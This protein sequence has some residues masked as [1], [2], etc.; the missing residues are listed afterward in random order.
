M[1][2]KIKDGVRIG[3]VDVFN[4]DGEL[5]VNSPTTTK[6][7][8]SRTISLSG[9]VTGSV[10]FDGSS[11]VS[12]T[13]TIGAN[14]VALGTDTTGNYVATV[15]SSGGTVSVTGSGSETAAINVDLPNSGVTAGSY[16]SATSIPVLTVDA[17][18]RITVATTASISTALGIAGD[19]G[20]DDV[21]LGSDTLTFVGTDPIDTAVTN[22]TVTISAKD[23]T[24]SSK[25]VASFA[26]ADFAVS[27][28]AVSISN[29]NLGTQTTGNYVATIAGTSNQVT[30]TGSGSETAAVTLSLPQ[31]IHTGASPTFAGATLDAIT[32]GVTGATTIDTTSGNLTINSAGG[33]TTVDDNL[34]VSGNL[35]VNGTTTTINSTITSIDDPI[36]TL[37]G[38]V[39]P[40]VNDAKDRG[41]E[42]RWHNGTDAKVGFFGYDAST[43][44][45][46]FIPDATNT[47]EVF[48]GTK[49][50]IDANIDWA[51]V[52]NKPDPVVT[53]TLTGDVTG[54]GNATLTDLA[55]GTISF[56]T[57][58]AANSVALGTDTTGNYVATVAGTANQVTVSGSGSETAAITLSLPQDIH[59]QATPTFSGVKFGV[60]G[61]ETA[62][63]K[64][65]TTTLATTTTTA[66]DSFAVGTYRSAKYVMQITQ[67]TNYQVSEVLVIHN[68]TTTFMTE[69]G[70]LETNGSLA[71]FSS[72]ISAGN[73]RLLVTMASA[74][75]ATINIKRTALVV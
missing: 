22:N 67:G 66:I 59:T 19:T 29:V 27:S 15:A 70:V 71:T 20:T 64:A 32:V 36:F 35:T 7:A 69:Y 40:T 33:T 23:A 75:S 58:I 54:T 57:T 41:I 9:D 2:F 10:S 17:Q 14:S 5:L 61:T 6:L 50:T 38:D 18:G 31:D 42:Y 45:F 44:K 55:S 34:V 63:D 16:G 43:S 37:G 3:S 47:S 26:S 24:T 72:D 28:G 48:S 53:V 4:N 56:A 21:S 60:T 11:N 13:T 62:L 49:G 8:N 51:D 25:G 1:A 30:V 12:I 74:T 68:G 46:T 52:L 65:V 39:A 73:A